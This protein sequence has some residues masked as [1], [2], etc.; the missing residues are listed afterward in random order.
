MSTPSCNG[1]NTG[2]TFISDTPTMISEQVRR[3]PDSVAISAGCNHVTYGELG[4]RS[5]CLARHV[6]AA[7][8]GL[9]GVAAVCLEPSAE[10]IIA[11]FGVMQA[12]GA[13]L[14][15]DPTYPSERLSFM[16][17]DSGAS[18]LITTRRLSEL[19]TIPK[20]VSVV[21]IRAVSNSDDEATLERFDTDDRLAYLIY[22][23]GST[24]EPKGVE[25]TH[26][27]LSNLVAWHNS[28]FGISHTD[29]ASQVAALGFDA[30]VWE[31]WPY[32]CAGATLCIPKDHVRRDASAL[33]DW[34]IGERITVTFVP[35]MMAEKLLSMDWPK[36]GSLRY[37]LTGGDA[38]R[39]YPDK[40]LWFTLVNNYGPTESTV[41]ATSGIVARQNGN[42]APS[43]GCPILNTEIY[44]LDEDLNPVPS[45]MPGELCIGGPS[46]ARGYRNRPHLTQEKFIKHPFSSVP[47]ARLYRTGDVARVQRDGELE[48]LGRVDDQIKIRG[49]RI[50]PNE[51]ALAVRRH[52]AVSDAV[53]I[54]REDE[55]GDKRLVAYIVTE[56]EEMIEHGAVRDFLRRTLPEHMIPSAFVVLEE[57]PLTE[58]GKLDRAALCTPD[59]QNTLKNNARVLPQTPIEERIAKIVCDLLKIDQIDRQDNFFMLGGHSLLGT[60]LIARIQETLGVRLSLR[61]LFECPTVTA[62]ASEVERLLYVRLEEMTE[63]EAEQLLKCA[64]QSGVRGI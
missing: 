4:R 19:M 60:Q 35:T 45:G 61:N 49:Y 53:V 17:A 56:K 58:N 26:R 13:Y 64:A 6:R 8:I 29:R 22:T 5:K 44:I 23:S 62:L 50:E 36:P 27:G 52:S 54:V 30:A 28:A 55:L 10:F 34:L 9:D 21:D 40:E 57:L 39:S 16:L 51:I 47:G 3:R 48:F 46:L 24:G 20:S 59:Q 41:V 33:R 14:P 7:G 38:L 1:T 18:V 12:G 43:L 25:V 31:I 37:L 11:A 63:D 42:V 32:L 2:H 15:L